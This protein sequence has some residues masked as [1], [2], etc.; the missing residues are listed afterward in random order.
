MH[1]QTDLFPPIRLIDPIR[2]IGLIGPVRPTPFL[3]NSKN[4]PI[5]RCDTCSI[6]C[7]KANKP[8]QQ[9]GTP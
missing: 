1:H 3:A 9:G 6:N 8:R 2:L 4:F 5:D 7:D